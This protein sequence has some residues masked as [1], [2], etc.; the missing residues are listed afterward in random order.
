[1]IT[2]HR[3]TEPPRPLFSTSVP[4]CLGVSF[5]ALFVIASTAPVSAADWPQFRGNPHLTGVASDAPP[6]A[7]KVLWSYELGDM[8]DSSPAIAG[9]VVYAGAANGTLAALDLATGKLRWK[10]ST[11][12]PL[13]IGESSPAVA[14][15]AVYVGD[16]DGVVHAV[17]SADGKRI[18]TF[19][20][21][22]EI[23]ASPIVVNGL[24]I[25][26]SYDTHLYALDARTGALR[27]KFQIKGQVHATPAVQGDVL[28][29]AGCDEV[30]RA[31]RIADGRQLY[32]I[33]T[34]AYTGASPVID[35]DRAYVGTFEY[36]VIALDLKARRVLWRY[37]DKERQFP[38]Y[39]SA[40]VANGRVVLGGR[41][42][43]IHAIDAGTGKAA[44]TFTTRARVDSSPAVAGGRVYVGSGDGRF[45]VLD[46][47]TGQKQW[48]F[49]AGSGITAS[50]AI[51]GGRVV[52]VSND[53]I[54]YCFG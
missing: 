30:F 40:S 22:S 4:R 17:N 47:A 24:V 26:G 53:G 18:W 1:M 35:G 15:G 48:E 16:L 20:T 29:L 45:Y 11:G 10:Y 36:E 44:W 7:L 5:L 9:G 3:G 25:I 38:F 31:I 32:E 49:E 6:A 46:L 14:A 50:P 41:D 43:L 2:T 12:G 21:G 13:G 8:N 23:K 51:S 54:V 37:S 19:K 28:F 33:P 52:I 42:K 34:G 39:S 27:W